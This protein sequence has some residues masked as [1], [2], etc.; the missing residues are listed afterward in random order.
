MFGLFSGGPMFGLF[1]GG[2]MFGLFWLFGFMFSGGPIC[3]VRHRD[4]NESITE[5]KEH[6][7]RLHT[8][9]GD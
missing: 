6:R 8:F 2:P 9:G 4:A 3:C 7:L 5:R 1:S